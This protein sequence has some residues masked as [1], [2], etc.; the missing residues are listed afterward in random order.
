MFTYYIIS[1]SIVKPKH[2]CRNTHYI[3][4]VINHSPFLLLLTYVIIRILYFKIIWYGGYITYEFY[5]IR[6]KYLLLNICY[7]SIMICI[8]LRATGLIK[9]IIR[10]LYKSTYIPFILIYFSKNP[11][12][13]LKQDVFECLLTRRKNPFSGL[14]HVLP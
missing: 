11:P 8:K 7:K 14:Y 12:H 9:K 13:E 3:I 5:F 1:S 2:L 4:I 10:N 6:V